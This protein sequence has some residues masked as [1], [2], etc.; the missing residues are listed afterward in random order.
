VSYDEP[1][2]VLDKDGLRIEVNFEEHPAFSPREWDNLTKMVCLHKRYQLGDDHRYTEDMFSSWGELRDE[3]E[4]DHDV[5]AIEPI[6]MY[7]HSG[8]TIS[9]SPFRSSWDSGQ[10]GWIFITEERLDTMGM[11]DE[12][13]T[14]ERFDKVIDSDIDVYDKYIRG[15]VYRFTVEDK[16]T[17]EILDSCSGFYERDM[18]LDEAK[19]IVETILDRRREARQEKLKALIENDVHLQEREKILAEMEG[20]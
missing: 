9:T 10:I 18:A 3:I 20:G 17:G 8:I 19:R 11:K 13:R 6:Y 2:K 14:E 7:D 16:K 5:V 4:R 12:H 1:L 15:E